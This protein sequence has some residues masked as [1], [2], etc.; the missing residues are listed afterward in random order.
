V[1]NKSIFD[2]SNSKSESSVFLIVPPKEDVRIISIEE[3]RHKIT[4]K[5]VFIIYSG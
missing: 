1:G 3:K 2:L 4:I 5:S